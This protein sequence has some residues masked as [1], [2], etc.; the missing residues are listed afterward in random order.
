M[1]Y[2]EIGLIALGIG[3]IAALVFVWLAITAPEGWQDEETGFH[4]GREPGEGDQ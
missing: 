2:G 1:T 4:Y 3:I